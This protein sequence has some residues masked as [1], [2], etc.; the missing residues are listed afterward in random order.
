VIKSDKLLEPKNPFIPLIRCT[1]VVM[2][3]ENTTRYFLQIEKNPDG[4]Y[5]GCIHQGNPAGNV[6]V[7]NLLL[8]PNDCI[9]NLSLKELVDDLS[10][11]DENNPL[12]PYL[13]ASSQSKIGQYLFK[14][15]IARLEAIHQLPLDEK[16]ELRILCPDEHIAGLPWVLLWNTG[17]FLATANCSVT[18]ALA[19]RKKTEPEPVKLPYYPKILIIAPQPNDVQSTEAQAHIEELCHLFEPEIVE[20]YIRFAHT[21]DEFRTQAESFQ[22]EIIYYYG[23]GK[24]DI[25]N[26]FLVFADQNQQTCQKPILDFAQVLDNLKKKPLLAY[27]NCCQGD[28][29]GLLGVG[30]QLGH[31]IPAVLTNRMTAQIEAAR[32]QALAFLGGLLLG[33]LTPHEAVTKMRRDLMTTFNDPRWMTPVLYCHYRNWNPIKRD[34]DLRLKLDR[35]RQFDPMLNQIEDMLESQKKNSIAYIWFG[36]EGQGVETFHERLASDL[37]NK[38]SNKGILTERKNPAWPDDFKIP[39]RSFEDM[40][41]QCFEKANSIDDIPLYLPK[42]ASKR[43]LLY[44]SHKPIQTLRIDEK[45]TNE[46]LIKDY[47]KWWDNQ[48]VPHLQKYQIFGLLGISFIVSQPAQFSKKF[49]ET[50]KNL[51]WELEHTR[52]HLLDEMANITEHELFHFLE[53]IAPLSNLQRK[54]LATLIIQKTKGHFEKTLGDIE[55]IAYHHKW[56]YQSFF[57]EENTRKTGVLTRIFRK[58]LKKS[59]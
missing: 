49:S 24:G 13:N 31:F 9:E 52:C 38:I 37:L 10:T 19:G 54:E 26:A 2:K 17:K 34:N 53:E 25:D 5:R 7:D 33:G 35:L 22:A 12:K 29:G 27:I 8:K 32:Q 48:I 14:E 44:I 59:K 45:L 51:D 36:Q 56:H 20:K 42:G 50:L 30:Q 1:R 47:L 55:K 28:A 40:Y 57:D 41:L 21:W 4:T 15:T 16:L 43:T 6:W 3:M 58:F 18:L 46:E 23:H 39:N 11:H